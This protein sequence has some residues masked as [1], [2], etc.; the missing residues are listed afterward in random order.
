MNERKN[1]AGIIYCHALFEEMQVQNTE[2]LA[3]SKMYLLNWEARNR[4]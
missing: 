2:E 3:Y 1:R 4:T